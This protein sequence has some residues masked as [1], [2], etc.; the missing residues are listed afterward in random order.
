MM[1]CFGF[2]NQKSEKIP[3]FTMKTRPVKGSDDWV[4]YIHT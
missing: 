2:K 4:C 3:K 1:S